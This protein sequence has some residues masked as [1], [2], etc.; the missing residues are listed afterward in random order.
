MGTEMKQSQTTETPKV[1]KT[2]ETNPISPHDTV[3]FDVRGQ[4][5]RTT[6]TTLKKCPDSL[7]YKLVNYEIAKS[8]GPSNQMPAEIFIDRDPDLFM[9]ILRSYDKTLNCN[10]VIDR[11]AVSRELEYFGLPKLASSSYQKEYKKELVF[12][13]RHG[14]Y[15][16]NAG[17]LTPAPPVIGTLAQMQGDQILA[18]WAL[19]PKCIRTN[20][21]E[22]LSQLQ[23]GT[24]GE[25]KWLLSYFKTHIGG[26]LEESVSIICIVQDYPEL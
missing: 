3:V 17:S 20:V 12:I 23:E 24:E 11:E 16:K 9:T 22:K 5:I 19:S 1:S 25:G 15:L 14:T 7:L 26:E 2:L 18:N 13:Q 10:S 8:G 4:K 21:S 6:F